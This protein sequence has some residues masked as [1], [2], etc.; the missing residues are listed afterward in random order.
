MNKILDKKTEIW[1]QMERKTPEQIET[2][3]NFYNQE[4]MPL[5]EEDYISRNRDK[6]DTA[7]K[8]LIVSVGNSCEPIILNIRLFQ[9]EK[10][11]FLC[12]KDSEH[13]LNQVVSYTQILPDSYERCRVSPVE[14]DSCYQAIKRCY[15][16]WGR[17]QKICIDFTGGTKAM[18]TAAAMA[19]A[20][21]NIQVVYVGSTWNPKLKKPIPGSE[22]LY[23]ISNPLLV[24]GDL[25]MEKAFSFFG[26]YAYAGA[27]QKIQ[28]I[29]NNMPDP[30][31]RQQLEYA[32]LLAQTYGE[33][34]AFNF[35]NASKKITELINDLNRDRNH[36]NYLLMD[37][38]EV[39]K[40]QAVI[41]ESLKRIQRNIRDRSYKKIL[42]DNEAYTALIFTMYQ[43]AVIREQ[44]KKYDMATLLYYRLLEMIVQKRLYIYNLLTSDMNYENISVPAG[45]MPEWEALSK[46]E[47]IRKLKETFSDI[48]N[49]VFRVQEA[50]IPEKAGLLDGFI[51]LSILH[52]PVTKPH[53]AKLEQFLNEIR[54]MADLRNSSIFAHGFQAIGWTK[55]YERFR[56]FVKKQ[57]LIFF[58][59]EGE[60]FEGYM[61]QIKWIDPKDSSNY[62]IG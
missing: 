13:T 47:Q 37:F 16:E 24:F 46:Q 56:R 33:W 39:L 50:Y 31:I 57:I 25:E 8:Y 51:I 38:I 48:K 29:Q 1:M 60:D 5:V 4:I 21:T 54:S 32:G 35:T 2:A 28:E 10:I 45:Q 3:D 7:I 53:A 43:C 18:S 34:D 27:G 49:Q 41:L 58:Q 52:D 15:T 26:Q 6:V 44:Q 19:G 23:Y 14:S 20:F 22:T 55:N 42:S 36:T 12:T 30:V 62:P 61:K 40:Q 11:M 17:P 9:P 59:T